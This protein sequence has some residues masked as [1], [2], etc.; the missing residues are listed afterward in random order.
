MND[1]AVSADAR[2]M[3]E[4]EIADEKSRL[5]FE[6]MTQTPVPK[7]VLT[8]AAPAIA[9]ML[10]V[11]I[12]NT[13]DTFFV[14]QLGTSATGAVSVVFSLMGILQSIG[15]MISMGCGLLV[16]RLLGAKQTEKASQVASTGFFMAVVFGAVFGA[17]CMIFTRPIVQILGS[18]PTIEPYAMQY[19]FYVMMAAPFMCSSFVMNNTLR[20][21]GKAS[22]SMIGI[23]FGGI[24]NIILDPIFIYTLNMGIKGAAIAT[25]ISQFVSF[26]ILLFMFLSGKSD[27]K[28][29]I[30]HISFKI[31]IYFE[32]LKT[33]FPS[34]CRQVTS[35]LAAMCVNWQAKAYGDVALAG[36]G[37]NSRIFILL[38]S[39]LVGLGQGLQ[40]VVSYSY[41]AKIYSR[42]KE[43]L[44]FAIKLG[45]LIMVAVGILG[46]VFAENI[47]GIFISDDV[48]VMTIGAFAFRAQCIV[49]PTFG[50]T[51]M[52]T[53]ASQCT[54]KTKMATFLSLS[55]QLI[56]FI[57]AIFVLPLAMGIT[58]VQIAQPVADIITFL[59]SIPLLISY[60]KEL[61][62]LQS[63]A[64]KKT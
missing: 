63:D 32:I 47:I 59:V 51:L 56:F 12:Y 27:I 7:L 42:A 23:M 8:L 34:F 31:G 46:F 1:K 39:V 6:K 5:H 33:G 49:L 64:I 30:K 25:A 62:K 40:P 54:G 53:M 45:T 15:F 9:S 26:T 29:H 18:T 52:F 4:S 13:A 28:L 14:S 22:L 50:V 48:A 55:R 17:T 41:G 20:G 16:A 57:P 19:T 24:L 11:S 61:N 35:S 58:G 2:E 37:V 3:L 60:Y 44:V 36:M 43:T 38:Y 21:I 10:V